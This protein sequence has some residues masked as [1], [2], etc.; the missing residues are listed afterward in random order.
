VHFRKALEIDPNNAMACFNLGNALLRK[1]EV[2]AA[3][4]Y[5]EKALNLRPNFAEVHVNLGNL[6]LDRGQMDEAIA[7]YEK[8]LQIRPDFGEAGNNLNRVAWVLATCPEASV[9]NGARAIE[10]AQELALVS[11]GND[12]VILGT[13]AAAYAEAGRFSDAV[14]VAQQAL[15]LAISQT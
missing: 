12:P 7:H 2:N 3:F 11:A 15:Q 6:C 4:A 1:R 10:L 8:A 5:Y 14:T 9:R 13:L